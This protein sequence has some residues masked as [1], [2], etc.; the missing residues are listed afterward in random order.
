MEL[1]SALQ[2]RDR[3]SRRDSLNQ[4]VSL[5]RDGQ[6]RLSAHDT[7]ALY[8]GLFEQDDQLCYVAIWNLLEHAPTNESVATTA[9]KILSD[10]EALCRG[11]AITHLLKSEVD[12]QDQYLT[13]YSNDPDPEVQDAIA[14]FLMPN[15]QRSAVRHWMN[16][17][18]SPNITHDLAETIPYSLASAVDSSD[19]PILASKAD[20]AGP[21]SL[22]DIVASLA[23][24][25]LN[26]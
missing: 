24:R 14:R 3:E 8:H 20:A 5:V 13:A 11:Q 9:R 25:R 7:Q 15:D 4:F 19:L 1:D 26:S 17:L 16:A 18:D 6:Y 2:I 23:H 21:G 12:T 10:V 22:W